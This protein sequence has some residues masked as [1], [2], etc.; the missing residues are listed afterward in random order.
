MSP[1][2]TAPDPAIPPAVQTRT[3]TV[4]GHELTLFMESPLMADT[5]VADICSARGRVWV[6]VYMILDDA[7]GRAVADA[8]KDRARAGLDVRL[9]YDFIGSYITPASFFDDLAEAGVQVHAFHSVWEAFWKFSPARLLNRRDHRKLAVIDDRVAYF[10][11][12][13]V[14]DPASNAA[15]E[16]AEHLLASAGWRDVHVR[17]A[18]PQQREVAES[19]DRAWRRAHGE[20]VAWRPRAYRAGLLAPGTESIQFFDSGPGLGYSRAARLFGRLIGAARRRVTLS[21]AYFLPVGGV[22]RALLRAPKR[23]VAV[24]VVV[25]ADSDVPVIQHATRHLYA[26]LLRRRFRIYERERNMLHSKVMVVDDQW[27]VL[28]SCNLDARSLYINLEFL[29][30]IHSRTLARALNRLIRF[31]IANSKRVTLREY[32][33]RNWWRRLVN[34]L[35]WTLRWWL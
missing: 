10:G 34:W 31:E 25:P 35:A 2:V 13:N 27:T 12:M 5:L 9:L 26:W 11:G 3:V 17:L 8:L 15:V 30:V 24:R 22:L 21:M 23:G 7:V 14:V 20:T 32:R 33:E 19:F 28:G 16:Q 18:G 4:A 29:A 6:E 1:D